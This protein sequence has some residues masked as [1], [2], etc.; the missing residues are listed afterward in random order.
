MVFNFKKNSRSVSEQF[1][2]LYQNRYCDQEEFSIAVFNGESHSRNV[3][4]YKPFL[5][6]NFD[7]KT[8]LPS[9]PKPEFGCK[10]VSIGSD[11]YVLCQVKHNL[12]SILK[13]SSSTK[14]WNKLPELKNVNPIYHVCSFMQKVFIISGNKRCVFYNKNT[15]N[16]V[17]Q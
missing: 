12:L 7:T 2:V 5:L 6:N 13:Y 9:L 10:V 15:Y 8:Y 16:P 14:T 3:E 17:H 4:S 11:I 1:P